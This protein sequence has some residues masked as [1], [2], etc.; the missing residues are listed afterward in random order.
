MDL[1][2]DLV[3]VIPGIT[4][5]VLEKDGKVVWGWSGSA[6]WRTLASGGATIRGLA[7]CGDDP[8]LDD[9]GDG[10]TAT[11]LMP[12]A[13]L[14]PG[15]WKIDGYSALRRLVTESFAVQT[16]DVAHV[17]AAN[18]FEFPYDWRRDNRVAAR[19]LQRLIHEAL[20]QWRKHSGADDAKVIVLAHSMGGLVARHW[21]EVLEGWHCCRALITFG[22]P[23]RGA[24][25]AMGYLANGYKMLF[26]LSETMRSF[27]SVY[28]LLP[29]YP[30]V[31]AGDDVWE[32]VAECDAHPQIDR[33]KASQALQFH[34]DIEDAVKRHQ[35]DPVYLKPATSYR[36][37]P[38]VG[39]SQPTWQSGVAAA[40]DLRLEELLPV[41][42]E[43]TFAA[44]DGTVPRVSATPIELSDSFAE[45]FIAGR[46]AA[47]QS[48]GVI[49][50]PQFQQSGFPGRRSGSAPELTASPRS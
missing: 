43:A 15:L 3:I 39:V 28:Q 13:H 50:A 16:G 32:R 24:P 35:D 11:K 41:N 49:I 37:L 44:G 2:R 30:A 48:N 29:I 47:L 12:D 18:Y 31:R 27:T 17:S 45:T 36:I 8:S 10:V 4:G 7:L 34:R 22:T 26:D 14:V 46:H 20:P 1:L 23:Y 6:L 42:I 40:G 38:V 25:Q 5:N 19:A 21:L 33:T 9:L